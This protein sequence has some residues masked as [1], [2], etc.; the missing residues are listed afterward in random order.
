MSNLTGFSEACYDTNSILEL[1][2][3]L[4]QRA[5]DATDC[6][7][8]GITPGQWRAAIVEAL[9]AKKA[10]ATKQLLIQ[11]ANRRDTM[12]KITTID[13]IPGY[14]QAIFSG[15][16]WNVDGEE[17][18]WSHRATKGKCEAVVLEVCLRLGI[19]EAFAP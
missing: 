12:S 16:I 17:Q 3:A 4:Q 5:A 10:S 9:A 2:E 1:E 6:K 7:A 15:Y 19:E 8:W 18:R 14:A 13:E 11:P